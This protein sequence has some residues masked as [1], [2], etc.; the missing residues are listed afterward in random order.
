MS[1][2]CE[3]FLSGRGLCIGLIAQRRGFLSSVL[4]RR[5]E[6][7]GHDLKSNRRAI[8]K[9]KSLSFNS[10]L[11]LHLMGV[12]ENMKFSSYCLRCSVFVLRK[13]SN[14]MCMLQIISAFLTPR[15]TIVVCCTFT[16]RI[17]QPRHPPNNIQSEDHLWLLTP[18]AYSQLPSLLVVDV[19]SAIC[20]LRAVGVPVTSG[21]INP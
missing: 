15:V 21:P 14:N 10:V 18:S 9:K 1:V 16:V 4:C 2:S 11:L 8:G 5:T 3:C 7:G 13:F 19:V 12:L 20:S 17:H 6:R